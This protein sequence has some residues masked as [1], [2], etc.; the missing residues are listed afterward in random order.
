[1]GC[2]IACFGRRGLKPLNLKMLV[3]KAPVKITSKLILIEYCC[4]LLVVKKLV[5]SKMRINPE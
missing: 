3:L 4:L 2:G 5:V 1:M